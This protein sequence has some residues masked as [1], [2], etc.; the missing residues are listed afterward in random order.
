MPRP[1]L[2]LPH[3]IVRLFVFFLSRACQDVLLRATTRV[4]DDGGVSLPIRVGGSDRA[5]L[6]GARPRVFPVRNVE[7]AVRGLFHE[8]AGD[9][10][11][12]LSHAGTT[13]DLVARRGGAKTYGVP[14]EAQH[15]NTPHRPLGGRADA[16]TARLPPETTTSS[17]SAPLFSR[18]NAHISARF[19]S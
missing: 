4:P 17:L 7:V 3:F 11:L 1:C 8:H 14:A 18:L 5:A 2:L 16:G 15:P 9:L 6:P 13:V 19:L 12:R 10:S